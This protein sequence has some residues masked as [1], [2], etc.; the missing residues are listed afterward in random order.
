MSAK[1]VKKEKEKK[2]KK[3]G[4][5]KVILF[6]LLVIAILLLILYFGKGGFG[7]G[8]GQGNGDGS[9]ESVEAMATTAAQT[10]APVTEESGPIVIEINESSIL[11]GADKTFDSYEAFEE[12]FYENKSDDA[13]YI[14]LDKQGIKSVY[15]SVEALLD[16]FGLNYSCGAVTQ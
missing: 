13:E 2:K 5:G 1:E 10:D 3:G 11:Y 15:D 12:Y 6:L 7:F 4:A 16:S 8:G 9:G 14:I